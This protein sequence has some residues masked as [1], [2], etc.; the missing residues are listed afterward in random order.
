MKPLLLPVG[1]ELH[2]TAARCKVGRSDEERE[3]NDVTAKA[4]ELWISTAAS[5]RYR[6]VVWLLVNLCLT[7]EHNEK[8][9]FHRSNGRVKNG[10]GHTK[11]RL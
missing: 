1:P 11:E 2:G 5:M 4:I 7:N 8:R 3:M 6:E 9:F 10:C